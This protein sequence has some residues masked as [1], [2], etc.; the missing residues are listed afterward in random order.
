VWTP[1]GGE[2]EG[3]EGKEIRLVE[4]GRREAREKMGRSWGRL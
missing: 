4:I 3:F 2:L 1:R